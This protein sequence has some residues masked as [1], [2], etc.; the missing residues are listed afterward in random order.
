[1]ALVYIGKYRYEI[2]EQ[3]EVPVWNTGTVSMNMEGDI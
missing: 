3:Q 2:Q 1:M